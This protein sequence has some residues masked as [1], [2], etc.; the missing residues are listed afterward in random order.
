MNIFNSRNRIQFFSLFVLVLPFLA[1]LISA[2]PI[3]GSTMA[4]QAA[5]CQSGVGGHLFSNGG[6]LE[7]EMVA[8]QAGFNIDLYLMS[9]GPQRF[10]AS[11]R[12]AGLVV[13]LGKFPAGVELIFGVFVRD[14]QDTYLMGSG[15]G[16]PDGLPHAEVTCFSNKRSGIGFE[17]QWGG[18]DKDYD[19]LL[20][21]VRQPLN[22]CAYTISP[23]SQSF[24]SAGGRG[25][26]SLNSSAGC[27]WS[28]TSSVNWVTITSGGSGSDSGTVNYSVALNTSSDSRTGTITSQ[29]ETFTVFQDA[30]GGRPVIT[31]TQ[32]KNKKMF[33]FGINFDAGSVVLLNGEEQKT[34]HDESRLDT[35]LVGKKLGK[36]AGPGDRIQVRSSAGLLSDEYIY[37]P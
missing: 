13:K 14:T 27:S 8:S 23:S 1:P 3:Q 35:F 32:L 26:V 19:D 31:G 30:A 20:C 29:G 4:P 9:P 16:N 28:A 10:V 18:G 12:D 6:D 37:N 2:P 24:G 34:L 36:R 22:G 33:I 7:V 15:S 17:D 5:E 11:N 25:S 21:T